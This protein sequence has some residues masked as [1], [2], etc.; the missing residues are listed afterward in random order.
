MNR[1]HVTDAAGGV[2]SSTIRRQNTS[3]S[4]RERSRNHSTM[5][6]YYN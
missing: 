4:R 2:G 3:P 6:R 5:E 1:V